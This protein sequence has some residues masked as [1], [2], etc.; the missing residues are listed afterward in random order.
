MF[1]P[2]RQ[3]GAGEG[4]KSAV[5]DCILSRVTT[6]PILMLSFLIATGRQG[7]GREGKGREGK[8]REGKQ[9]GCILLVMTE[10]LPAVWNRLPAILTVS[11]Q[12]SFLFHSTVDLAH[13][14]ND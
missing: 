12:T 6:D 1:H 3:V 5:S 8:G 4:A 11:S 7:K 2:V 9:S 13:V 10:A 14:K